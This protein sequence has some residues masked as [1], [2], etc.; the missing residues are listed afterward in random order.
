MVTMRLSAVKDRRVEEIR[1]DTNSRIPSWALR[2]E[3]ARPTGAGSPAPSRSSREMAG[4]VDGDS[5]PIPVSLETGIAEASRPSTAIHWS[6]RSRGFRC[7][8]GSPVYGKSI[9]SA[10][11]LTSSRFFRRGVLENAPQFYAVVARAESAAS[12]ANLQRAV[13]ER[14]PN[15]SVID[16]TLVLNTL[17]SLLGRVSDAIRVVALFTILTGCAVLASAVLSSRTQRVKE[18]I[19]LGTLGAPRRQI[20]TS[21]IAEY[22]FWG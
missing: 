19:L 22:V 8:L 2:R 6:S 17:D 1:A 13:V 10:C 16:L 11:S 12:S 20:V 3:Y 14:F 9:G 4:K 18:S 15:V 21:V 5:Q 7:G